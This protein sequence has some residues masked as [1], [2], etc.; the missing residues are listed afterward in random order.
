[1]TTTELAAPPTTAVP[2]PKRRPLLTAPAVALVL[3]TAGVL[4]RL[5]LTAV[6]A[7]PTNSDEGTMGLA[8]LHILDGREHP[9]F[10]YGQHYMGT[11]EAYLAAPLLA[12]AGPSVLALRLPALL[13][14]AAFLWLMYRLTRRLYTPWLAAATVGL[15]S[16][17]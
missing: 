8:A 12:V 1:M 4:Y 16:F 17:G 5:V 13:C 6:E 14:Y 3:G 10:F 2:P 9:A 11:L 15:L 7:P